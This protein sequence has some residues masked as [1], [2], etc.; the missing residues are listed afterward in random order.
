MIRISGRAGLFC[1][2]LV[3]GLVDDVSSTPPTYFRSRLNFQC[4]E[5]EVRILDTQIYERK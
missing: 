1:T 5:D 3:T 2:A 4:P